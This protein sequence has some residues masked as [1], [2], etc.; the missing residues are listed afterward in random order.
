[1]KIICVGR[2]Y[3]EHAKEMKSEI[4]TQPVIFLK[5]DTA[6]LRNNKPFFLPD[7]SHHIEYEAELVFRIG[8]NGKHVEEKFAHKYVDAITLGVDFTARDIQN[9]MKKKGLP[10]ELA[11]AFDNSAGIG[12]LFPIDKFKEPYHFYMLR[13]GEKV[14][15]ADSSLMLFS[16]PKLLSFVSQH[17]ALRQG[18]FLFTGTPV[19]VGKLEPEDVLKGFLEEEQVFSFKI[20]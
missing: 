3:A 7:W 18:D 15:Q 6:L 17:I 16:V 8:R 2:N 19:G 5:P 1:M 12:K 10:W 14:Q 11:K 4:P 13:N 9:E 20:K